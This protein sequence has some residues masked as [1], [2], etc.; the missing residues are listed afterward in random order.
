M[1]LIVTALAVVSV[2][3]VAFATSANVKL[4]EDPNP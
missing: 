2:D 1:P 3:K 4:L